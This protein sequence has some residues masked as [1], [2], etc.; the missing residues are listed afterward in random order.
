MCLEYK[1]FIKVSHVIVY[2]PYTKIIW[3]L[4]ILLVATENFQVL[5]GKAP[6]VIQYYTNSQVKNKV[7][8]YRKNRTEHRDKNQTCQ[9]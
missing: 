3:R 8:N 2:L 1:I 9:T 5:G 7:I 6:K 4:F